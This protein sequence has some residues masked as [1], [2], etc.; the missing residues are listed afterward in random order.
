M[1]SISS[2]SGP[3]ERGCL[4]R[5]QLVEL[6]VAAVGDGRV[7]GCSCIVMTR[8]RHLEPDGAHQRDGVAARDRARLHA[9]VELHLAALEP[10]LEVHVDGPRRQRPA[11]AVSARSCVVIRPMA[12][13]SSRLRSTPDAPTSRSCEFVP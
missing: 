6:Q 7:R 11:I 5:E 4:Q 1:K 10:V 2:C 13:R 3:S 12:P 8:P 9:V